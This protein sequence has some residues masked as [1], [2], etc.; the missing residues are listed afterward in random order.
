NVASVRNQPRLQGLAQALLVSEAAQRGDVTEI[1]ALLED[2]DAWRGFHSGPPRFVLGALT[3]AVAAQPAHPAWRPSLGRWLQSWNPTPLAP[4]ALR[5]A[6][7]AGLTRPEPESAQPLPGQTPAPW[8]LHQAARAIGR[9]DYGSAL[10]FV[11]RA[12]DADTDLANFPDPETVRELL[13]DLERLVRAADLAAMISPE[14]EPPS[15]PGLLA[16]FV[17]LLETV[18]EGSALFT[19]ARRGDGSEVWEILNGLADRPD[20]PPAL[21]HH[22]AVTHLRCARA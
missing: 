11:R 5:L 18:P 17:T 21:A 13:P 20:L 12:L 10:V 8:F 14:G 15:N 22:L 4:E 3:S 7:I 19:A 1:A 9:D 6:E 16:D 2:V